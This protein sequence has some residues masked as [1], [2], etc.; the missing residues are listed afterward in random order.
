M[1]KKERIK[2]LEKRNFEIEETIRF[3]L[4]DRENHLKSWERVSKDME[5][6]QNNF[7]V[8]QE[9]FKTQS[10][11]NLKQ[12]TFNDAFLALLDAKN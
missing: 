1:T 6:F 5:R 7:K 10:E 11:F 8:V 3:L 4:K 9:N 2:E 12:K